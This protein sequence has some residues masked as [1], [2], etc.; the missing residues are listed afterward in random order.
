VEIENRLRGEE[1]EKGRATGEM[2]RSV[3]AVKE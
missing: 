2:G 1:R 3:N